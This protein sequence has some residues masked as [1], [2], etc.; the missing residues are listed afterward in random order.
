MT[1]LKNLRLIFQDAQTNDE[2]DNSLRLQSNN[3]IRKKIQRVR[4]L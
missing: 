3:R 2:E 4:N 1:A